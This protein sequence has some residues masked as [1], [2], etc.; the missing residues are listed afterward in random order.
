M[1]EV[2]SSALDRIFDTLKNLGERLAVVESD[3]KTA[4]HNHGKDLDD[5]EARLRTLE[6]ADLVSRK[7]MEQAAKERSTRF[8]VVAAV[9]VTVLVAV[10]GPIE[11]VVITRVFGQ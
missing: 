7:E 5:H 6:Q 3:L 11:T 4:L 2:T 8:W 1:T 9:V 10:V